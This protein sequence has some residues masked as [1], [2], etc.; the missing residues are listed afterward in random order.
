VSSELREKEN[1]GVPRRQPSPRLADV[2][3]EHGRPG[4]EELL[5]TREVSW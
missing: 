5:S 2:E 4:E 3:L 1:G